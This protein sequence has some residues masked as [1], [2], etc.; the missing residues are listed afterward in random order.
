MLWINWVISTIFLAMEK[1]DDLF[2]LSPLSS[3]F[4]WFK[5][6]NCF[7]K[8]FLTLC[9]FDSSRISSLT[10]ITSSISFTPS[11]I[12]TPRSITELRTIFVFER[13]LTTFFSPLSIFFAITTS[14]LLESRLTPPISLRYCLTGSPTISLFSC[15]G[16]VVF[17]FGRLTSLISFSFK[18]SLRNF[19]FVLIT[20]SLSKRLDI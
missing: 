10:S 18:K 1:L 17:G 16:D 13:A 11:R 14:S 3:L 9:F 15:P 5:V 4:S 12:S 7:R 8:W 19:R 20:S 2:F 6:S